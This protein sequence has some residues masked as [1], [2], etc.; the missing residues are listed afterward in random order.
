MRE[1]EKK[2][3]HTIKI[4]KIKKRENQA[5]QNKRRGA[6]K[7]EWIDDSTNRVST[8][9]TNSQNG[10]LSQPIPVA[11]YIVLFFCSSGSLKRG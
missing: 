3:R 5:D 4:T 10:S 11:Q 9:S 7:E 1:W 2:K 8:N 6:T